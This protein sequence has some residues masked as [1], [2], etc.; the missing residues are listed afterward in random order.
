MANEPN[1]YDALLGRT[2]MRHLDA[3]VLTL[4]KLVIT[5]RTMATELGLATP[6]AIVRFGAM[7]AD[8]G[9]KSVADLAK[10]S[11]VDLADYPGCG[12]TTCY[13]AIRV[14]QHAGID[15]RQWYAEHVTYHT[16][17]RRAASAAAE[18]AS[19]RRKVQ[20]ARTKRGTS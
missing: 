8:L 7:C 12:V 9:I 20:T 10:R 18:R 3:P 13:V 15:V 6:V 1:G 17:Q 2:F 14:L 4:G 16:L 19:A 11:P 5:R